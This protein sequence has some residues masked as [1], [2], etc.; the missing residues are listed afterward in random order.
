MVENDQV[1]ILKNK[2]R[3]LEERLEI[4]NTHIYPDEKLVNDI[5]RQ[6][7]RIKDELANLRA[8]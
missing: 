7:L 4:E 3:K 1:E 6:K 5:K 2:H 8:L